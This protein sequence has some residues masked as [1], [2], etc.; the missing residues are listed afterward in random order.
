ML[1]RAVNGFELGGATSGKQNA[2]RLAAI[3][4]DCILVKFRFVCLLDPGMYFL[5]AGVAGA[6]NGEDK[7]LHRIVDALCFRVMNVRSQNSTG[8]VDFSCTPELILNPK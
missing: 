8:I 4:G 6:I 5:N 2:D 1:I 3:K 7:H